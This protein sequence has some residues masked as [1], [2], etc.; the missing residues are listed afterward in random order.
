MKIYD[1]T[2][3][4]GTQSK[5][6]NLTVKDK[7]SILELLDKAG[8]DYAELGWPGSN[9]KDMEAFV[10]A[11]RL[12]LKNLKIAAFCST[13]RKDTKAKDDLN[14]QAVLRSKAP[15]ATVFGKT[16]LDH[17]SKQLKTTP[18]ENLQAIKDSIIFL[19][20]NNLT[21]FYDAEHFFDGYKD[22]EEYA[23][24]CLTTAFN[25]GAEVAILCDTNG[26]C[27]PQEIKKIVNEVKKHFPNNKLGIHCHNDAGCAVANTL[28]CTDKINQIQG[29][30]NG[31]GER[32]G[33]ADLC[34][35]I[36]AL[37]LK[38]NIQTNFNLKALKKVSDMAY[39]LSNMKEDAQQPYVG[40]NAFAHKGGVH[41]DAINKGAVYEH[42]TPESVGNKRDIVLSDLSGSANVVEV[43]KKFNLNIDKKDP[44]V[45]DMLN[46]I[47]EMEKNGYDIQDLEAEKYLLMHKHFISKKM[48]FSIDMKNWKITTGKKNG[49][50]FSEC[51]ITG[52]V[53]GD[54]L[55]VVMPVENNGPVDSAYKAL[56]ELI[57]HKY[58]QIKD[59]NL[60]NFKVMIAQ[61][62]GVES[63]VRVF[64]Q[65]KNHS[66]EFGT[67][68]VNTNI[69]E[70]SIEAIIKAFQY[71]LL[72]NSKQEL[73][74]QDC[75]NSSNSI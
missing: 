17:I 33:N 36:P 67:T 23:I 28:V 52:K 32:T 38:L 51:H 25:A 34:Q 20:E 48:P 15:V 74:S 40:K 16:W 12:K 46:D 6:V 45:K 11:S 24:N 37:E 7:L 8:V 60:V 31:F 57:S 3:R 71:Y 64:I 41:V 63:S 2:L 39:V 69:I 75:A 59:I 26:G 21:V 5:A 53:N 4:D 9:P 29:T 58:K 61:D 14:L 54:N 66:E 43:L 27:L 73:I 35:I 72:K 65:F 30:L 1:T 62:K 10:L 19:K 42:I 49:T 55:N 13:R 44:R 68:G 18:E 22:N 47:K 56:K 70:A 50:E